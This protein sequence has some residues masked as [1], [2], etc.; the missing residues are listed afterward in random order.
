MAA[1]SDLLFEQNTNTISSRFEGA[2]ISMNIPT[3]RAYRLVPRGGGGPARDEAGFA[4]FCRL[5][6]IGPGQPARRP[7]GRLYGRPV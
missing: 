6:C 5:N 3:Q 4:I 2:H 7:E 1:K